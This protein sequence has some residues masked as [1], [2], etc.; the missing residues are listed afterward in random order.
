MRVQRAVLSA[1]AAAALLAAVGR[2]EPL[3]RL[4]GKVVTDRAEPVPLADVRVE[5]R[6]GFAGSDF[7]G[8]RTYAAKANAKGEWTIIGFTAGIWV[9]DAAAPGRAPDAVALPFNLV[10]PAG[11]AMA[12]AI[13]T[14]QPILKLEP[15]P[16]GDVGRRLAEA[17]DAARARE[18]SRV[19]PMLVELDD[20]DPNI[21]NALGHICLLMADDGAARA[22]FHR[23]LDRD[24]GSFAAALGMASTALLQR[25]FDAAARAYGAARD[26]TADKAEQRYLTAAIRDLSKIHVGGPDLQILADPREQLRPR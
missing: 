5:A 17:A 1:A 6:F 9:F 18:T 8:Q 11:Q 21:L 12:D 26:L 19:R 3:S 22:F 15:L 20:A 16:A 25:D 7:T 24:P 10:T 4:R 13:P 14:W 23:A 2:A